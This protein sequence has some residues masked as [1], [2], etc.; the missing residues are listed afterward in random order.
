MIQKINVFQDIFNR[1][2]WSCGRYWNRRS[3]FLSTLISLGQ[4]WYHPQLTTVE[5]SS[6][7]YQF[8]STAP[9]NI[10]VIGKS[11]SSSAEQATARR[12]IRYEQLLVCLR[13]GLRKGTVW[14]N[15][16]VSLG[17]RLNPEIITTT[18]RRQVIREH[19]ILIIAHLSARLSPPTTVLDGTWYRYHR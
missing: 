1:T 9:F 15:A 13:K 16:S 7:S 4:G 11:S 5:Y 3:T 18:F 6:S 19:W 8:D 17:M 14:I 2:R 12:E 10:I